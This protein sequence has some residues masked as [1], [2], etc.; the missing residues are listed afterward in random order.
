MN[1]EISEQPQERSKRASKGRKRSLSISENSRKSV[2]SEKVPKRGKVGKFRVEGRVF[3]LTYTQ[4]GSEGQV[5]TKES[6]R[7]ALMEHRFGES[8]HPTHYLICRQHY[9]QGGV[10]FHV[11]LVYSHRKNV[12]KAEYFDVQ[13]V[14]PN[15][16]RLRN[17]LA[18]LEYVVKEDRQPL[19]NLDI[20]RERIVERASSSGP[21]LY[22]L[23]QQQML[24]DP[25]SFDV[26]EYCRTHGLFCHIIKTDFSKAMGL[27]RSAQEV[28]CRNRLRERPLMRQI[29]RSLV[30][31]V[32]TPAQLVQY[33][34][35]PCYARVVRHVNQVVRWNN[36]SPATRPPDKTRHLYLVGPSDIGKTALVCHHP[37][38]THPYPGLDAYFSTYYL[39]L[40]ERFFPPYTAYMSSLVYWDEFVLSSSVFPKSRFNE[41]LTY[42][43]GVPT[44]LPIK[45]RL[46][47]RRIDFPK[48]ILTSNLTLN[49]QVENVFSSPSNRDK[50]RSALRSRLQ[51]VRVPK[52]CSLHLLRRL[53]IPP[54]REVR[55]PLLEERI[56]PL[57]GGV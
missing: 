13:G 4:K 31:C 21:N 42:L 2:K 33:D 9:V 43:A 17:R 26:Y 19:T 38:S 56:C 50:A 40:A 45:G 1:K 49:E 36:L 39:N 41:L 8:L 18:A 46:P 25:F 14:H 54:F 37:N 20:E 23:L 11:I 28:Q 5:L 52:G 55:P 12:L 29:T 30:E 7:D 35:H 32:L 53:F 27:L 34:R 22:A 51:Q 16:G 44:Q 24:K 47:V 48:H 10:H 15:V 3:F 6:L 57:D